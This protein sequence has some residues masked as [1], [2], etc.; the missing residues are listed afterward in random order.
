[1][2]MARSDHKACCDHETATTGKSTHPTSGIYT[3]PMHPEVRQ[4][5]PGSCP[6]C[7]MALEPERISLETL[8][9]PDPELIDM[10]RRFWVSAILTL[11]LFVIAMG[12]MLPGQPISAIIGD[13]TGFL[14]ALLATPVVLWGG[15]PFFVRGIQSLRGFNLNMF[16]LIGLGVS[17]AYGYSLAAL[18]FP[19]LFPDEML[20]HDGM[21]GVYF[22]SAAVI[23]TLVLL[24]QVLELKARGATSGAIRALLKL[25]PTHAR[26]INPDGSD[27]DIP[28]EAIEKGDR[29][30]VRPGEKIPVDGEITDGTSTVDEAMITGEAMPVEKRPGDPVTGGTLN[31]AGGFIMR[32]TAIGDDTL[33]SKIVAMVSE[34]QRSRAPIQRLVDRV[35]AWFIPLVI[36]IAIVSFIVWMLVGPEPRHIYAIISAVSVLIIACPCALGLATPMSIMVGTGR[37]AGEGVLIRTGE[38]LETLGSLDIVVVDKTGTLTEGRPALSSLKTAAGLG[39]DAALRFAASLELGS[40]HPLAAAIIRHAKDKAIKTTEPDAFQSHSGMGVS[41]SLD[42]HIL[43]LGNRA[44]MANAGITLDP[45]LDDAAQKAR[46]RGETAIYLAVDKTLRA[47]IGLSDTI[48]ASTP[49]AIR[50]LHDGGIKIVMLTGDNETTARHI[51]RELGIDE[52]HADILPEDKARIVS[53]LM[54]QGHRVAMAGDGINDAIA[55]ATAHVGIAM[56]T[57]TDIAIESSGVTL[58]KGDLRGIAKAI[59]LSRATMRNIR[60]NLFFAFSYNALGIPIAAGVL[61]PIFGVMLSPMIAAAAMSLSSVSVIGN[62]LRLR[63]V[64]L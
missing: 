60:Q 50:A 12:D 9:T 46:E 15:W 2:H 33:L 55:L 62:A 34:A 8:A 47:V 44:L 40:E 14:Q 64:S 13:K 58:V 5:G 30:R 36:L 29:I 57:G 10:R 48:K 59:R 24:G 32:A 52:V 3:C 54:A 28:V 27:T 11:P 4:E 61:F 19:D 25:A 7:G 51:A 53:G 17:V 1:M 39:E 38:A 56:G 6:K 43:H 41:G 45:I 26:R 31:H 16:T 22:E 20:G 42:G 35:S 21:V 49:D 18:L 37:G 63:R 23:T